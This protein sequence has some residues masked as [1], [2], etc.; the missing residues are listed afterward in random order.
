MKILYC[1]A[2]ISLISCSE[3]IENRCFVDDESEVFQSYTEKKPFTVQQILEKKPDYLEIINLKKYRSFKIDSME[4]HNHRDSDEV[5]EKK[6]KQYTDDFEVF[7]NKFSGQFMFSDKQQVGNSL[8][9]LGKNQLGSWLLK[10]END[11]PSAYFLGL[12][13]SYYYLNNIQNN[14]IINNGFLQFEGSLVKI[15]KVAGLPGYDDYSAIEDG[16]LFKIKLEDL[17]KDS[18]HDGYNDIFEKCFG[19]NPHSKDSDGDGINDFEDLNPM[20]K[21][22]KNKFSELYNMLL[23]K[24]SDNSNFK[25]MHYTFVPFESDCDYFHQINPELRVLFIPENNREKTQYIKVTDVV[26][27]GVRIK[28]EK[29][30]HNKFHIYQSFSSGSNSFPAEYK[31]GKWEF[32]EITQTIS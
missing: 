7:E 17:M 6:W 29:N 31:N 19:L 26:R 4:S 14:P 32:G 30:N 24:Y 2:F 8:Y 12:S 23:P 13:F 5:A 28:K 15:V 10:I 16:K 21:S 1:L 18:D 25:K 9:A 27:N 3:S 22:E 20:Y 11:I